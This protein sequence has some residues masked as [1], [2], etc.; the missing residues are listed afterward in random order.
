MAAF[1][2]NFAN[3]GTKLVTSLGSQTSI[4]EEFM[5]ESGKVIVSTIV[6]TPVI[7]FDQGKYKKFLH[8]NSLSPTNAK[9]PFAQ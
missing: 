6:D 3:D 1:S 8:N 5:L 2:L 7:E 9:E 4:Q